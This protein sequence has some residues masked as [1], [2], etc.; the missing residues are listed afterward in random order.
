MTFVT[1]LLAVMFT[2]VDY[3]HLLP[4]ITFLEDDYVFIK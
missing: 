2:I 3:D 1:D 4:F